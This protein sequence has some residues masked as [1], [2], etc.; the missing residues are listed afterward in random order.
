ME[1]KNSSYRL[2]CIKIHIWTVYK[3]SS[4]A[5]KSPFDTSKA[6]YR[7]IVFYTA[8]TEHISPVTLNEL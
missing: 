5:V 4:I 7:N 2:K 1:E 8:R 6:H 3:F